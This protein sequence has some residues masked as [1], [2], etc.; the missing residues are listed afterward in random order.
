LQEI[1]A[2]QNEIFEKIDPDSAVVLGLARNSASKE[3]LIG[4]AAQHT[5]TFDLLYNADEICSAYG[6]LLDPTYAIIDGEGRLVFK[7]SGYYFYRMSKLVTAFNDVI[8][9]L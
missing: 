3:W 1:P 4:Y 2:I 5:V 6:A 8:S 7:D 9:G